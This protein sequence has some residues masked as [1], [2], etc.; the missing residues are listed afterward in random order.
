[1]VVFYLK[2]TFMKC[3]DSRVSDKTFYKTFARTNPSDKL[4]VRSLLVLLK[5]YRWSK[6][7]IISE[8]NNPYMSIAQNLEKQVSNNTNFTINHNGIKYFPNQYICCEDKQKCC[9]DIFSDVVD[10]TY[11]S[12]RV[13]VFFGRLAD[14]IELMTKLQMRKLLDNGEYVIIYIDLEA[15]SESTAYRYFWRMDM[16]QHLVDTTLKAAGSLLVIVPTPPQAAGYAEFEENVRKYNFEEPFSFPNKLPYPKHITEFAA[17]LY[18][19]VI[20]YAEAL[21]KTLD[22]DGDPRNGTNIIQKIISRGMYQSVTGAWMHIDDNG[23][24]E[25]NYTVLALQPTPPN[26]TLKGLGGERLSHLMLPMAQFQYDEETG[27]P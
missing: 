24:V 6:F 12:T 9:R 17:Y 3:S 16:R 1:M 15:Y 25:G 18:D 2:H 13:Y 19:S 23:D 20:L 11:K 5:Y 27:E 26:L 14:L 22:E 4:V 8:G 21:A 7:S 10:E